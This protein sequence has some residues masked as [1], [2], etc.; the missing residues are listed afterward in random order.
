M[1][2]AIA[3]GAFFHNELLLGA[4]ERGRAAPAAPDG[5]AQR[6]RRALA[7]RASLRAA[8]HGPAKQSRARVHSLLPRRPRHAAAQRHRFPAPAAAKDARTRHRPHRLALRPLLRHG[9]R[10]SLGAHRARLSRRRA[11]RSRSARPDPVEAVRQSYEQGVT[12]EF[13]LPVVIT[14]G[15]GAAAPPVA[16]VRDDDAV[17][18][19]NFRADRARQMTA[20]HRRARLRQIRRSRRGRR[21]CSIVAMTQYDKSFAWL[22]FVFGPEKLE[23]ILAQVFADVDCATCASRKPRNTRTSLTFSTAA[24]RSR[25]PARSASWCLAQSADLRFE[26]GNVRR[27][28]RRQRDSG[29]RKG[30]F[31]R[32]HHE[33][34]QRRHGRPFRQTRSRPFKAVE[35]VDPASAASFSRCNRAAAPGSSP[36]ITAMPKP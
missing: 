32:R 24:S 5:P 31:R 13:I 36:P 6:R 26:A 35:T 1:D 25:F 27:G 12:D 15:R 3:S 21:I 7:H 33:F 20:R 28:H 2:H 19:F 30:R 22:R 17:I 10:Q 29:H 8:A 18:F 11:R 4:M 23:Q 9:S 14:D 34:R 16:C